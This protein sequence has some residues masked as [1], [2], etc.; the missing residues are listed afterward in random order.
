MNLDANVR[1]E[2]L[3]NAAAEG[4][5]PRLELLI[6]AGANLDYEDQNGYTALHK[7]TIRNDEDCIKLLL[8]NGANINARR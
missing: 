5:R 3:L 7:A 8:E 1:N 6:G 4:Q 2:K